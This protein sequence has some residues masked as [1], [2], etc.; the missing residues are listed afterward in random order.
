MTVQRSEWAGRPL[1]ITWLPP[2]FRPP[3]DLTTQAAGLCFTAEG[4]IVLIT[5]DGA[6]WGLPGGHP[7]GD[8]TLEATLAREVWEE[9]RAVVTR[10]AYLGSQ[11]VD[12]PRAPDG[13][14]RYYQA[15][16]WARVELRPFVAEWETMAR[17]LVSPD[18]FLAM[19]AWGQAPI[20][21]VILEEGLL[22]DRRHGTVGGEGA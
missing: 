13:L 8:E 2:P 22:A 10:C 3:R 17:R 14:T 5:G 7:E 19:L 1:T 21:R 6:E 16:F 9:A 4:R 18:Q 20:A 15:R 12:D 11:R